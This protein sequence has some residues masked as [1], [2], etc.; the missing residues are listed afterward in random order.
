MK[1]GEQAAYRR[2]TSSRKKRANPVS[3]AAA[4]PQLNQLSGVSWQ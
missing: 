4:C 1:D 3:S 2:L